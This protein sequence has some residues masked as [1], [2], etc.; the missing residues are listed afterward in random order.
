MTIRTYILLAYLLVVGG[1]FYYL[2]N[3]N[4]S[5]LAPRYLE[6][7]EEALVDSVNI[8]ASVIES[9]TRDDTLDPAK[10]KTMFDGAFRRRFNALIYSLNK[11]QVNARV[12]VTDADGIVLYDSREGRDEGKSYRNEWRDVI[13]TL[14]GE[15]GA[16]A[17]HEVKGDPHS[18]M[19]YMAAPI[20]SRDGSRLIGIVSLGK[21]ADSINELVSAAR[22]RVVLAGL[23]GGGMILLLGIAFSMWVTAPITRLTQYARAVRDGRSAKMPKLANFEGREVRELRKAFEE[24]RAAIE[25]KAYVER[26]VQTLTHEIKSPLSAIRGAA[27]I[28]GENPPEAERARFI[29]NINTEAGRIQRIVDQLLQLASLEARK[30][31]AKMVAL[32]LASV[33]RETFAVFQP[34]AQTGGVELLIDAPAPAPMRGDRALL[35]QA[36][37][38]LLQNAI[39]FTPAGGRV[40]LRVETDA[41]THEIVAIVEDNGSGIPDYAAG[42]L[43]EKFYSLARPRSGVKST[44]LGLSLV[45]E[46]A[47]LHGG[48]ATIAN[49]KDGER[50]TRAELR[51]SQGRLL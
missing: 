39:E 22:K 15:Y 38:N 16:R 44:G 5:E 45:R 13:L 48:V 40:V 24:M 30:A 34:A 46:I 1:G 3:R 4:L 25:G 6:S 35:A 17:T 32:D 31:H 23:A 42:R 26:Y 49:R 11:T 41:K 8:L 7:M 36:L 19:L 18:L 27:E 21:P 10:I 43:F 51:F 14:R 20:R 28:L 37:G 12:Y 47:H 9:E 2:I 29:G 50:G 33:A